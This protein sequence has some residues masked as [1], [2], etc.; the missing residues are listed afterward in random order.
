MGER[1]A[2]ERDWGRWGERRV[3]R[4]LRLRG[5][6]ILAQNYRCGYGEVDIIAQRLGVVAFVEVK[7]RHGDG[8][9]G[10]MAAVTRVKRERLRR[11]AAHYLQ[12]R[13][14]PR[15]CRF[16]VAALSLHPRTGRPRLH[17]LAGAFDGAE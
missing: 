15:H 2:E 17:Y 12:G 8:Y 16:D 11:V 14:P 1:R 9:G 3:R 4:Y 6:R 7:T 5:Y 13:R 10:P